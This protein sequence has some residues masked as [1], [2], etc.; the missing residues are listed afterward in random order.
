MR[1]SYMKIQN[2]S[3]HGSHAS[4][5]VTNRRMHWQPEY[6]MPHQLLRSWGHN[7]TISIIRLLHAWSSDFNSF[8]FTQIEVFKWPGVCACVRVWVCVVCVCGCDRELNCCL[9]E[10]SCSRHLTWYH[11]TLTL[12]RPGLAIP[13]TSHCKKR[14]RQYHFDD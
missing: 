10:V 2:T 9:N 7:K 1:N 6:N 5:S 12:C 8:F 4:K 3:M 14:I 13:R 11:I